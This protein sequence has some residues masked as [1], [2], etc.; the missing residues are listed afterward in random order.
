MDHRERAR[1]HARDRVDTVRG[2]FGAPTSETL[3]AVKV[4]V[5]VLVAV[6]LAA[7]VF[8]QKRRAKRLA[9]PVDIAKLRR[10]RMATLGSKVCA[11]V[12][13][14]LLPSSHD[15]AAGVLCAGNGSTSDC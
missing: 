2:M 11:G 15:A 9:E 10:K 13:P 4:V 14:I 1:V 6:F 8:R 7:K 5:L 12:V 3:A